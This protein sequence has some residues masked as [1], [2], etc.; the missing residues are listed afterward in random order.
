MPQAVQSSI[1]LSYL[2][3]SG[4]QVFVRLSSLQVDDS[5]ALSVPPDYA[6]GDAYLKRLYATGVI[7]AVEGGTGTAAMT[8]SAAD[9]GSLG[10]NISVT[11]AA[12]AGD[13]SAS[14]IALSFRDAR[15]GLTTT[16]IVRELGDDGGTVGSKPSLVRVKGAVAGAPDDQDVPLTNGGASTRASATLTDAAG[17]TALTLEA[18]GVG[19]DG[20]STRVVISNA[21]TASDGT[22]TFDM[23]VTWEMT[24]A[25]V[26]AANL[27]TEI[28]KAAY[29]VSAA[30]PSGASALSPPAAGAVRLAG[31]EDARRASATPLASSG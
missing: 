5:G 14:D 30:P 25:A 12:N 29:L 26:T 23:T 27:S 15:T 31:G 16:S 7:T 4:S 9:W 20:D 17:G 13:A 8:L 18:K 21:S 11:F 1:T 2:S 28:A 10:N 24:L 3:S 6:E 19:T 22:T